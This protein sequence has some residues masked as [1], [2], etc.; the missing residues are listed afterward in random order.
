MPLPPAP[1]PP[2]PSLGPHRIRTPLRRAHPCR[3]LRRIPHHHIRPLTHRHRP[4]GRRPHGEARHAEHRR[5]L[6]QAARIR[7]H[8]VR[9]IHQ[10]QHL[11]VPE[12]IDHRHAGIDSAAPRA[13]APASADAPE[14]RPAAPPPPPSTPRRAR[15]AAADH[16]RSTADATSPPPAVACPATAAPARRARGNA[17]STLSIMTFPTN[18]IFV[19]RLTLRAAT[20]RPH[21]ATA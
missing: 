14:T 20:S 12:R 19:R 15:R 11:Q 1:P 7:D 8:R 16:P 9:R 2:I 17:C 18:T 13:A 21:P 5:L 6:L 10:R 3:N 4:L